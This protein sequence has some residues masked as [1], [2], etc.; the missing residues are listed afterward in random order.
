[1]TGALLLAAS[2]ALAGQ[3]FDACHDLSR[4][5]AMAMLTAPLSPAAASPDSHEGWDRDAG[6]PTEIRRAGDGM[7]YLD[8]MVNDRPHR[9]L[10]DTGAS[11]VV[12]SRSDAR[13]L[14]I[15]ASAGDGR[16]FRTVGGQRAADLAQMDLLVMGGRRLSDVEV[17]IVEDD[18]I[19]VSLL[20][21]SALQRME[22]ITIEGDRMLIH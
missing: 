1:M 4:D 11:I 13:A 9:F 20:G 8:A 21:Q 18:G 12:L 3:W 19:G 17:A 5:S 14:G 6:Q 16:M 2:A 10:V 22:R 15:R 7:F